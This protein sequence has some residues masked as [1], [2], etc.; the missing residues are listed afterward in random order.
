MN[1]KNAFIIN[2]DNVRNA[3]RQNDQ[4]NVQEQCQ[5]DRP[6]VPLRPPINQSQQ[7]IVHPNDKDLF[8]DPNRVLHIFNLPFDTTIDEISRFF[9]GYQVEHIRII[10]TAAGRHSGTALVQFPT[11]DAADRALQQLQRRTIGD[12]TVLL[13]PAINDHIRSYREGEFCTRMRQRDDDLEFERE[14]RRQRDY[15]NH[16]SSDTYRDLKEEI[17]LVNENLRAIAEALNTNFSRLNQQVQFQRI[18]VRN[19]E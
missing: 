6:T 7:N 18:V 4:N 8:A 15:Y 5:Q 14:Y 13:V 17:A 2:I 11:N 3:A 1:H 16:F 12:K 19:Q 10:K 9:Q